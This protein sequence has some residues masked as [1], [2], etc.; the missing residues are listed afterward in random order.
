MK[1]GMVG[2][3]G[4]PA[5]GGIE[6]HV[7]NVGA[8]LVERGHEVAAY[9]RRQYTDP[10]LGSGIRGVRRIFTRGVRGKH[11]DAITHTLTAA[12]HACFGRYDVI[13]IHGAGQSIVAPLLRLLSPRSR[14]VVTIHGLDWRRRKW[15]RLA[16]FLIRTAARLSVGVAHATVLISRA[17]QEAYRQEFGK[18]GDLAFPPNGVTPHPE[19]PGEILKLGLEP[20]RYMLVMARLVPEKGI[21]Y[22]LEAYKGL[23]T[24]VRLVVAGDANYKDP[25]ADGLR[26]MADERVLFPGYVRDRLQRELL[27][28]AY[29]YVT[30]SDLE[31]MPITVLEAMGYGRC[32][33]AS[34]IEPHQEALA[35]AGCLCP[36]GDVAA[37]RA[38]LAELLADPDR[39]ARCGELARK[40]ASELFTWERVTDVLEAI[41]ERLV[42]ERKRRGARGGA[43]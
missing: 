34:D 1:I 27:T 29:L 4:I 7:E 31:G 26:A 37:L 17:D 10:E 25:Y 42:G 13:H 2:C 36:V 28:H 39:V 5:M 24:D 3:K 19:E 23:E 15:G 20:G 9:C 6:T 33:V 32:V 22:L 41:Y 14:L 8:L 30:A 12:L 40:R 11:L 16:S 43:A 18:E 21:H 38:L 35:G